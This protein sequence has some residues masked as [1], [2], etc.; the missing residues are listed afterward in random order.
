MLFGTGTSRRIDLSL[1]EARL[2]R[3]AQHV[4]TGKGETPYPIFPFNS[5]IWCRCRTSKQ[6]YKTSYASLRGLK[7]LRHA[8]QSLAQLLDDGIAQMEDAVLPVSRHQGIM[9]LPN[10][11]IVK[12]MTLV[13]EQ[14]IFDPIQLKRT[15][16]TFFE[17]PPFGSLVNDAKTLLRYWK[18]SEAAWTGTLPDRRR[19][20][21]I[22]KLFM[23]MPTEHN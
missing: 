20:P 17:V 2:L 7:S 15:M 13:G 16:W 3:A 22:T 11:I 8:V 19:S 18:E 23:T 4:T 21:M 5:L 12:I 9:S 6:A 10:E 1:F 14:L